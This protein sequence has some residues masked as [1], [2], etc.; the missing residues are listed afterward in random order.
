MNEAAAATPP[1]AGRLLAVACLCARWCRLCGEYEA[2]F[3]RVAA[4]WPQLRFRWIDIED[5]ADLV[6]SIDVETFP[7]LLF[8]SDAGAS[9]FG[10]VEPHEATL[11]RLLA[12]Q[13]QDGA[14]PLR[15]MDGEVAA[16]AATLVGPA[17]PP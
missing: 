12:Q 3:A 15:E 11:E 9:F 14:V 2:V 8:V 10:A 6:G 5:E 16:L 1:T 7:T 4:R 13:V 17:R